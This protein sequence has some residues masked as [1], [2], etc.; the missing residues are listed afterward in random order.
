[1]SIW[2]EYAS[3]ISPELLS[4]CIEDTDE[5]DYENDILPVIKAALNDKYKMNL[6]SYNFNLVTKNLINNLMNLFDN[7]IEVKIIL[8]LGM[9]NGAGWVTT[10]DDESVIL[11]GI[12]KIVELN[13]H[14]E[15]CLQALIFHEI[16]HIWHKIVGKMFFPTNCPREQSIL[17]LYQEGIAMVCEQILCNDSGYYHQNKG[18]WLEWCLTNE[19]EIKKEYLY[20]IS[21]DESTQDFFGDWCNYKGYSDVGYF[22][23]CQFIKYLQ[24]KYKLK[25][26]ANLPYEA[27]ITEFKSFAK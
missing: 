6:V 8:Y 19:V 26:I 1:M 22:L 24:T 7:D 20:R 14:D 18:N 27:L 9:C 4:K 3:Q 16:G 15:E 11:L 13:W 21:I 23:G 25:E 12:E 17:Q 10:L 5:Y 2:R